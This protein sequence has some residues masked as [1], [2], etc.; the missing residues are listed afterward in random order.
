M[1]KGLT[2]AH[3]RPIWYHSEFQTSPIPQTSFLVGTFL[4]LLAARQFLSLVARW[5]N[6]T[7]IHVVSKLE[8]NW[9]FSV[10]VENTTKRQQT[11]CCL[12]NRLCLHGP[13][14][15]KRQLH[16]NRR[17]YFEGSCLTFWGPL[18]VN[19]LFYR[20]FGKIQVS[21]FAKEQQ[22]QIM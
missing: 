10:S 18:V 17:L 8:Q 14:S 7:E 11:A 12:G 9:Y 20:K 6:S 13:N 5:V 21:A 2:C 15:L 1:I 19:Q 22:Q 3:L 16:G 4:T